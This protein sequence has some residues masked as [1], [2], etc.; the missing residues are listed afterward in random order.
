MFNRLCIIGV[1]LIGGSIARAARMHGLTKSIVG[2]G[3]EQDSQNL[4]TAKRLRVIDDYYLDIETALQGADG[5]FIATPVGAIESILTLLKPYWSTKAVYT[6]VGSTKGNVIAAAERI[7]GAVPENLVPA[8]P[9]A[10]AE[11]SGVEAAVDDL[12][13]NKRL[14]LT[15]LNHTQARAVQILTV[16]WERMGALVSVMDAGH[17]DAILAATS[18]LPHILAFALVDMLGRKDEQTEIFK[19]AAGGFRDFTR[20]ASSDPTMWLDIC[21]ANKNQ[22]IPL[23]QQLKGELDKI[24]RLLTNDDFSQLFETFTY[25]RNARQRFLDQFEN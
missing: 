10:G 6:D 18:H 5:I 1:G 3:R 14:I 25:A 13:L 15:P 21:S 9:I 16:F 8:H 12:F 7:F 23:I 11:H 20:I 2:F 4:E 19:Y 17:H 24:E 22:L